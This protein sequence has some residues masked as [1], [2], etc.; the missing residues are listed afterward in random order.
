[1]DL[2]KDIKLW[3]RF[4][5]INGTFQKFHVGLWQAALIAFDKFFNRELDFIHLVP[6]FNLG[7]LLIGCSVRE[8][9]QGLTN[10]GLPFN[11]ARAEVFVGLENHEL[12]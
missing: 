10:V 5:Y 3:K 7:Q 9:F 4:F 2:C 11:D 1:M 6:C 8:V 12:S